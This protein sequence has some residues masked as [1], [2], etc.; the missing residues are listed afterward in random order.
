[1]KKTYKTKTVMKGRSFLLFIIFIFGLVFLSYKLVAINY[2]DNNNYKQTVLSQQVNNLTDTTNQVIPKRGSILDARGIALAES[3]MVYHVIFDPA[4][5]IEL[6]EEVQVATVAF[7]SD[8]LEGVE[9]TELERLL[10]E[11]YMSHYEIIAR[12]LTYPQAKPIMDAKDDR[13][14]G[15]VAFEEQY[16]REYP[17]DTMASDVIG[18]MQS[19]GVG[20]WGL[21]KVYDDYLTGAVGRRFG[22]VDGDNNIKQ[23]D[24]DAQEGYDITL[25]IDFTV[26]AY[27]EEAIENFYAEE[28]ALSVQVVI[29]N[30]QNAAVLGMASYPNYNLND[31][32]NIDALVTADEKASMTDADVTALRNQLWRNEVISDSYEPGSTFKPFTIAMALEEYLVT[33]ESTYVCNGY[34]I[35]YEGH[36][37]IYCH[38]VSG[39]GEQTLME[40]LSN[41][42]NVALM[43]IGV[44][45]GRDFFYEYQRMFGFGA[46]TF[47]DLTGETSVRS[48]VY[49]QEELNPVE[50]QTSSFGQGFNVTP[51]QL[52]TG[53]SALINGGNLY[54]PQVMNRVTDESGR[55]IVQNEPVLQRKVISEEV[56]DQMLNA[57]RQV[58]DEGTGAGARIEGY[59]VGG[60][61]GTAEKKDRETKD[62]VVS[63]I[64]FSPT[65]NPEV[66]CLVVVD[67]PVGVNVNSRYAAAIFKDIMED[68]LPY[69]RISK[70]YSETEAEQ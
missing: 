58:V 12:S 22:A 13:L 64:G 40:A 69:L 63:F 16:K 46:Q 44:T 2:F 7:L 42:C 36:K 41:S 3:N 25:N 34:K 60:K 30:P 57:L 53:F 31:P 55:L 26:Q 29:M 54:E 11:R 14:I 21:E 23:E 51:I 20:L 37:P 47:I 52:I 59:S 35:P 65:V 27:I 19:D 33:E 24:V 56:S 9:Q 48:L 49:T 61:T 68:V 5:L 6:D 15:G 43:D 45:V 1:M 70:V 62:Y 66:I 8:H 17:Y 38:K 18:F 10:K 4:V 39:H 50:L 28:E 67:D 32:Y